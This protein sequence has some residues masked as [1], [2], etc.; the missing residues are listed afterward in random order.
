MSTRCYSLNPFVP[1][2]VGPAHYGVELG[3]NHGKRDWAS[4]Y[5]IE[6]SDT[7]RARLD[8]RLIL[9]QQRSTQTTNVSGML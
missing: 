8:P 5:R 7:V 1:F 9:A 4:V 2:A 3:H 6:H